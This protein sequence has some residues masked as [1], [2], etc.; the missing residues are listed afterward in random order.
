MQLTS[1]ENIRDVVNDLNVKLIGSFLVKSKTSGI[2]VLSVYLK[3]KKMSMA[4]SNL[5]LTLPKDWFP[6]KHPAYFK[7]AFKGKFVKK[8]GDGTFEYESDKKDWTIVE[9]PPEQFHNYTVGWISPNVLVCVGMMMAYMPS[10]N[11]TGVACKVQIM[12]VDAKKPKWHCPPVYRDNPLGPAIATPYLFNT[13]N[14]TMI[15]CGGYNDDKDTFNGTY[16][17]DATVI[18]IVMMGPMRR[19]VK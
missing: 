10:E 2:Q 1:R 15:M 3:G 6:S 11:W 9:E 13:A 16:T 8:K 5:E 14:G 18:K 12:D 7:A 19:S 17:K 4:G